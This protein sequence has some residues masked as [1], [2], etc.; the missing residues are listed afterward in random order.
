MR[1][2][3]RWTTSRVACNGSVPLVGLILASI[4]LLVP[5]PRR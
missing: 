4:L 2:R 1:G 3:Y 5:D